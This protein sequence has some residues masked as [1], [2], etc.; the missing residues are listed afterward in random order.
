MLFSLSFLSFKSILNYISYIEHGPSNG[1]LDT[2]LSVIWTVGQS[3]V[4]LMDNWT[5]HC[6][7]NGQLG[8]ALS[9]Q[10]TIGHCNVHPMDRWTE[11]SSTNRQLNIALS[12]Q[13]TVGH[14]IVHLRGTFWPFYHVFWT[15]LVHQKSICPSSWITRMTCFSNPEYYKIYHTQ[16]YV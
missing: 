10:W 2:A 3:T 13:W 15:Q 6:P 8:R 5:E 16:I 7:S 1:Q 14:S 11:H 12:I 4:H 9:S